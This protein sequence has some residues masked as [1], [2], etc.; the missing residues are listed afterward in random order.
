MATPCQLAATRPS[1]ERTWLASAATAARVRPTSSPSPIGSTCRSCCAAA[2]P[3]AGLNSLTWHDA[4]TRIGT[5]S[6]PDRSALQE[7][8][9]GKPAP[10]VYAAQRDLQQPACNRAG[11][12]VYLLQLGLADLDS[13]RPPW[14]SAVVGKRA[15]PASQHRRCYLRTHP[16]SVTAS[17]PFQPHPWRRPGRGGDAEARKLLGA[18]LQLELP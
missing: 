10:S 11:T 13:A 6:A 17:S 8:A 16:R 4:R 12:P 1:S 2:E 15:W 14:Y 9:G 3:L 18:W 7:R 5:G